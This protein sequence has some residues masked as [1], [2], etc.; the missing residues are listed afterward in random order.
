[1]GADGNGGQG[2]HYNR[3]IDVLCVC[4]ANM[5]RSPMLEAFL[6]SVLRG[7]G[8]DAH[9][10]SAGTMADGRAAVTEVV[11]VVAERGLDLGGHRSRRLAP[12]LVAGADLVLPLA[13][14]HLREVVVTAPEAFPRTF[15][16]KEL[17]RRSSAVG[18][19]R[20]DEPLDAFLARLH[21]GRTAQELLRDDPAD[22]VADP[23]GGPYAA[24]A[25]TAGE[26]EQ[27]ALALAGVLAPTPTPGS[28]PA[29][30]PGSTPA[31]IPG[32]TPAPIPGSTPAPIPGSTPAP[33]FSLSPF[34]ET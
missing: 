33:T 7:R 31:P 1:M 5:C 17:L 14:E 28:T 10:H 30:I 26:L 22:D 3:L 15:T 19:R 24:Y 23:I 18:G 32:S 21:E 25:R 13:R 8:V 20:P 4:T 29:P 16:P 9:V 27:L 6:G 34:Q 2:R 11:E 12:E